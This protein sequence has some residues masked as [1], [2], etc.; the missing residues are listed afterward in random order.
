MNTHL[1]F[2]HFVILAAVGA[3]D[4]E[5]IDQNNTNDGNDESEKV[6]G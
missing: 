6:N 5:T 1:I 3:S 4:F 2:V